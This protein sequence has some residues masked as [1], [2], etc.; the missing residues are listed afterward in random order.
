[1]AGR[2][3]DLHLLQVLAKNARTAPVLYP[4]GDTS[5]VS[6]SGPRKRLLAGNQF[7]H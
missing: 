6:L 2:A 4:R 3:G 1:M 5:K 7:M